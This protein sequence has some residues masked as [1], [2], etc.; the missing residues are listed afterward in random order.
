MWPDDRV[1]HW[2]TC[3]GRVS[4][5]ARYPALSVASWP[6]SIWF[7]WLYPNS[8]VPPPITSYAVGKV[9]FLNAGASQDRLV[10]SIFRLNVLARIALEHGT[11]HRREERVAD[12]LTTCFASEARDYWRSG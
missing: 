5:T 12:L 8:D 11:E 2:I 9:R 1:F 7:D 3:V 4:A 10:P 6:P